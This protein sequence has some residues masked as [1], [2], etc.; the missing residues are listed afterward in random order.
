[1]TDNIG[2]THAAS[3]GRMRG[4][5]QWKATIQIAADL[6]R[7]WEIIDDISMIPS[8]HP[9]VR[10]VDLISGEEKRRAGAKYR[11]H[12][13]SGRRG[14]CVEEV[15][16]SVPNERISTAMGEDSWGLDRMLADFIVDTTVI[17]H[18]GNS[19]ILEFTAYYN[20]VGWRN[21]LLNALFLRRL[22]KRR[23]L[24]VMKGIKRLAEG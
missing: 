3:G 24:G 4:R 13:P 2:D 15:V 19:T 11:C 23:T 16:D 8:Y 22:M 12:I 5:F 1:M 20:P 10:K 7:V 6:R 21:R 18:G 9:E 17:P 14:S